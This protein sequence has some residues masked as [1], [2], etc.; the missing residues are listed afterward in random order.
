MTCRTHMEQFL[1]ELGLLSR[2]RDWWIVRTAVRNPSY[3]DIPSD[4][5]ITHAK[6][7]M[8]EGIE[9]LAMARTP[10]AIMRALPAQEMELIFGDPEPVA[11]S[12]QTFYFIKDGEIIGSLWLDMHATLKEKDRVHQANIGAFRLTLGDSSKHE[13][14]FQSYAKMINEI[15]A[16]ALVTDWLQA[17]G[18]ITRSKVSWFFPLIETKNELAND[19]LSD[20]WL[21]HSGRLHRLAASLG[22]ELELIANR[23]TTTETCRPGKQF[24]V[25]P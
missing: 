9:M 1:P 20:L 21:T 23:G 3:T 12:Q 22:I 24:Q 6:I 14:V 13:R 16:E 2:A 10:Q 11:D 5:R 7:K 8:L 19:C 4:V 25:A 17:V 18:V 15:I